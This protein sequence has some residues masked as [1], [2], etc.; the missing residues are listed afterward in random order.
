MASGDLSHARIAVIS[1]VDKNIELARKKG[2]TLQELSVL[3]KLCA[4]DKQ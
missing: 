1:G 2:N 3:S 4:E